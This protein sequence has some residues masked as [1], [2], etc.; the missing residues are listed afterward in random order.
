MKENYK[1]IS[2]N[3]LWIRKTPEFNGKAIGLVYPGETLSIVN[4]ENNFLRTKTGWISEYTAAGDVRLMERINPLIDSLT[5]TSNKSEEVKNDS[6][7]FVSASDVY[8][9]MLNNSI[10][11]SSNKSYVEAL[12][13]LDMETMRAVYG[14]PYQFLEHVDPRTRTLSGR[15]YGRVY[16]ERIVAKLPLLIIA[17][18]EPDFL[19]GFTED[20]RKKSLESI[21]R[22]VD[23]ASSGKFLKKIGQSDLD[24]LISDEGKYYSFRYNLSE[25]FNYLNPMLNNAARLLG[26]SDEK[27]FGEALGSY[28]WYTNQNSTV[29]DLWTGRQALAFYIESETQVSDSF[30]N[31][32]TVSAMASKINQFSDMSREL[33][34]LLGGPTAALGAEALKTSFNE[35]ELGNWASESLSATG[36]M[37][38]FIK[39]VAG[40]FNTVLTGGKLIFPNIWSDSGFM[41][42]Y[43]VSFKFVSPDYDDYSWYINC[44]VPVCHLMAL[45]IPRA[46]SV[47]GFMSPFLVRAFY[48]GLFNC[49]MGIITNLTISKGTEGGW[50]KS[51]LPTVI[52]CNITIKDLYSAIS[53][54]G[55]KGPLDF[56]KNSKILKN[57]IFMDYLANMCGINLNEPDLMRTISLYY[58]TLFEDRVNQFSSRIYAAAETAVMNTIA[59]SFNPFFFRR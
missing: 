2:K 6:N 26:I 43:D 1:V 8:D 39:Q 36:A 57:S 58:G 40:G 11:Q 29:H 56:E 34:F 14:A 45:T 54:T 4:K 25:Y 28:D 10:L 55:V 3:P 13:S 51:G 32:D 33:G 23:D 52:N 7:M 53:M 18:G 17:P 5:D 9:T 15:E 46:T 12:S 20:E 16:G 35:F 22:M 31:D 49:D 19:A 30:T 38:Q 50:T 42:S 24:D 47:N 48:K 37:A 59:S 44:L 41:R 27:Y 21:V